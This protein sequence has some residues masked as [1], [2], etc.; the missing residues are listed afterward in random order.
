MDS[1]NESYCWA[2][3]DASSWVIAASY[4]G[5]NGVIFD[6]CVGLEIFM[7]GQTSR[8]GN[9]LSVV[10]ALA[11]KYK[12]DRS[13][14]GREEGGGVVTNQGKNDK[15]SYYTELWCLL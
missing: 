11:W 10:L 4:V 15:L 7:M 12:E 6:L 13:L 1:I 9:L 3:K 8:E 5:E 14:S 2:S